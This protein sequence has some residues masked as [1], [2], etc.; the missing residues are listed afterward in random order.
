MSTIAIVRHVHLYALCHVIRND[1][2]RTKD[3]PLMDTAGTREGRGG[4]NSWILAVESTLPCRLLRRYTFP[5]PPKYRSS[6]ARLQDASRGSCDLPTIVVT[7]FLATTCTRFHNSSYV[8]ELR[9]SRRQPARETR[10][11]AGRGG[12]YIG[13][14]QCFLG[15]PILKSNLLHT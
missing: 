12:T 14:C 3:S 13:A 11:Q 6:A 15:E 5:A 9:S 10:L 8:I 4:L 1:A 7:Q 2:C